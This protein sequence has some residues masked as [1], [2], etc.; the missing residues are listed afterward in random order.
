MTTTTTSA[1]GSTIAYDV[2]GTGP[3][4]VLVD[5]ALCYREMGPSKDLA[6]ALSDRFTV[7]RYDRRGRGESTIATDATPGTTEAVEQEV[8]DLGAVIKAAGGHAYLLGQSSGAALALEA[9]RAGLPIDAVVAYEAPFILDDTQSPNDADLGDRVA[10][11]VKRGKRAA[12]V[13]LFMRTVGVPWLMVKVMRLTPVF[14]KLSAVAHTL[15]YDVSI[16]LPFQQGMALPK[17]YYEGVKVRVLSVAGSKSPTYMTNAQQAISQAIPD[18]RYVVLD[19][20]NHMVKASALAPVSAEF[21][22]A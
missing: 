9:A 11:L 5:G 10:R 1:D 18:G 19:G 3:A 6:A 15:P 2:T 22:T 16:V 4:L 7:Y 17:G 8:A 12:A 13:D 21:F 20:Q 14:R